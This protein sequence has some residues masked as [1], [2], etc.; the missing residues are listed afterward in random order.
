M[1][2]KMTVELAISRSAL[3][4]V[5]RAAFRSS[6]VDVIDWSVE[7]IVG[8][9]NRSSSVHRVRGT[10]RAGSKLRPW[11]VVLK[12]VQALPGYTDQHSPYYWLREAQAYTLGVLDE[13]SSGLVPARCLGTEASEST[14]HIW[15][16]DV[17]GV[18]GVSWSADQ[19]LVATRRFGA[20]HG[21]YLVGRALPSHPWLARDLRRRQAE[22][23]APARPRGCPRRSRALPYRSGSVGAAA[24]RG[25]RAR[26]RASLAW[27]LA[28]PN[29]NMYRSVPAR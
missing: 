29:H 11:S 1:R 25:A 8:G 15:L 21:G 27:L 6:H 20:F 19:V 5:V 28:G 14:V 22:E 23:A 9:L 7:P 3:T 12:V 2:G 16:E 13:L 24:G 10:A 26:A 4:P 17:D 18:L